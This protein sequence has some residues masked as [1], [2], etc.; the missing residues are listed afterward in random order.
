MKAKIT[1]LT[2][3]LIWF[4]QPL[5]S[6]DFITEW[7]FPTTSNQIRF[8]ALTA[9]GPVNYTWSAS[10]SGNSGSGS[11]I[12]TTAGAVTLSD[13]T[14]AAGDVVTLSLTPTNLRRFYIDNGPDRLRLT[15]VTQWG[16]TSWSSMERFFFGCENL[17]IIATDIPNLSG[18]TSMSNMFRNCTNIN[19]PN[20]I[21]SW[22]TSTITEM[23]S[24]FENASSFNIDIGAWD[25]SSVTSMASIFR[26][27][28][29]F[30]QDISSWNTSLVTNMISMFRDANNFNQDLNSWDTGSVTS[31]NAMFF[32]ATA[33][34]GNIGNWNTASVTN[35]V[36]MFRDASSFNQNIG[37]W[38]T[39][40]VTSMSNMFENALVFN[41]DIGSWNTS[42]V[43]NMSSMFKN[44]TAFNQDIGSW[45]TSVVTN[46][47]SIFDNASAFNQNIGNWN[48]ASVTNMSLM[49]RG[50]TSFNQDIGNWNTAAV[51]LMSGMFRGA[52]SFNQDIGNWNTTVVTIMSGMFE[53]ATSFNQDISSWSTSAVT[54]MTG[55]FRNASLFNQ[56][57]GNWQL[58]AN[59]NLIAMLD[60]C[61][62]DCNSYS[63]TLIGWQLNNPTV[64]GR[65]L[66]S[67]GLQYGTNAL[68]SRT[69]LTSSQGWTI[70][71][72]TA[73][74]I[75]CSVSNDI[76]FVTEWTFPT[77]STQI[78]FNALTADGPVTYEWSAAPS[79]NSGSGNFTQDVVGQVTLSGLDIAA[80]DVV[81]LFMTPNNLKRFFINNGPDRER[82]TNV[83]QW[84]TT[85]WTSMER[86][87]YGCS[88]LNIS[89]TD[90][91][92]L[93][94][95]TN[96]SQMFRSCINLNSPININSWNTQSVTDMSLLFYNAQSF[97]QELPNWNTDSVTTMSG[98]FEFAL[99]FNRDISS[100][101]TSSVTNMRGMFTVAE[102]FNQNIG[103]WDVSSV[104]DMAGMFLGAQ[105]FNQDISGWNVSAVNIMGQMF[106]GAI[107]FNQDISN[108][109]TANVNNMFAMFEFA[110]AFNQNLGSWV[111]KSDVEMS[112]MFDSSGMDCNS[113]SATLVGWQINNPSVINRTLGASGLTFGTAAIEA[114]NI[115]T[116]DRG[117]TISGDSAGSEA[118]DALL[119]TADFNLGDQVSI[120][121]NPSA[122]EFTIKFNTQ[123][124]NIDLE[125]YNINGQL[126]LN[127]TYQNVNEIRLNID[128]ATGIYFVKIYAN[129]RANTYK[130]VRL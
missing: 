84:G 85:N 10:P 102:V 25:T 108:W 124:E 129:D 78:R 79:G 3:I 48:I 109:N 74:A 1:L 52:T 13:L 93:S 51:T 73:V 114:R 14:I 36:F 63:N 103:S 5:Q 80:G 95:V 96:M 37:N 94:E 69:S 9:D 65:F 125:V 99:L 123:H 53:N 113:Y 118:C 88:N 35:M 59:V 33:F 101:N 116:N 64:N 44:A 47:S 24:V 111:L 43:T 112:F 81:T 41:Q 19:G 39:G 57:I 104:T 15:N 98:M 58:N 16:N 105:S 126:I 2:L 110:S 18:V 83:T 90:V 67:E 87:F 130:L 49:F 75:D 20:N 23:N 56:D 42:A 60:N 6:Q 38:D 100:W 115:L 55:M 92:N 32:G 76:P 45:N 46:M 54:A 66:G 97:N 117:W 107:N 72:D 122:Q 8:S 34:N 31:M 68:A 30:N 61:G 89:A 119:S 29:S 62:L 11:F 12:Q 7:T 128:S 91:P 22:N 106:Q 120:Y 82:L 26:N 70:L 50:A 127:K 86:A 40:T 28:G 21:G 121:P 77:A 4:V 71:G 27:S 17:Q